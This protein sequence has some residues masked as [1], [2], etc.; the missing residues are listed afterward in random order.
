MSQF[1]VEALHKRIEGH[2]TRQDM[3]PGSRYLCEKRFATE[4]GTNLRGPV[5]SLLSALTW[6]LDGLDECVH[7]T[8]DKG[9]H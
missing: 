3:V 1:V 7:V 6:S 4:K 9:R 2:Q 5:N 8:S